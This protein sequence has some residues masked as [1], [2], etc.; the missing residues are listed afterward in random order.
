[1]HIL[2]IGTGYVGLVSGACCNLARC[3]LARIAVVIVPVSV[4]HDGCV[5]GDG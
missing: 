4:G 2:I 1:M 3:I 5:A